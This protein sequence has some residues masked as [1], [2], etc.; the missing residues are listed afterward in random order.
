MLRGEG[1][2][3]IL[4]KDAPGAPAWSESLGAGWGGSLVWGGGGVE[5]RLYTLYP[6][7]LRAHSH[8]LSQATQHRTGELSPNSTLLGNLGE[9]LSIPVL[10]QGH[11]PPT[12]ADTQPMPARASPGKGAF[13]SKP[14][15]NQSETGLLPILNLYG[16]FLPGLARTHTH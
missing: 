14:Q 13:F 10:P 11:S 6:A 16:G 12:V 1:L 15:V 5:V 7:C 4:H 8:S 3:P 2:A 9:S